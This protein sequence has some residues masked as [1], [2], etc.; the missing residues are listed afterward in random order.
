MSQADQIRRA[1][2]N[3]R[4]KLQNMG[5]REHRVW[6]CTRTETGE[7]AILGTVGTK[8]DVDLEIS[9]RPVVELA[10]GDEYENVGPIQLNVG[11]IRISKI[12]RSVTFETLINDRNTIWKVTGPSLDGEYDLI[13]G[14]HEVKITEHIAILRRRPL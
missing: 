14:S 11:D 5:L 6:L 4:L 8:V 2:D 3:A 9:P 10:S 13:D 7:D 12:S 1:I